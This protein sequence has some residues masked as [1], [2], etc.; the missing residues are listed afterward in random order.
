MCTINEN[1]W[2]QLR[3]QRN[4]LMKFGKIIIKTFNYATPHDATG[5]SFIL[6]LLTYSLGFSFK[7]SLVFLLC[8]FQL[9]P[10]IF[11]KICY[12]FDEVIKKYN[13]VLLKR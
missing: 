2:H 11:A 13:L 5:F 10:V 4:I 9:F 7:F 3:S 6:W 1:R 8:P 12:E